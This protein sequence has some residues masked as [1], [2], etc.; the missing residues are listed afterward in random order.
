[1]SGWLDDVLGAYLD[2]VSER[3]FDGAFLALLASAG[4]SNIH[5]IH[6]AYEFGKDFIARRDGV[7]YGLQTKAGDI[8]LAPWR[9]IR[10]QIEEILWNDIAHPDFDVGLE[11]RAVLVTT[12]RLIGGAAAD[13]QQYASTL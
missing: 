11:R 5:L 8:G 13:A 2:A 12:G 7:Q 9:S 4:F 10:S 6:G 1:M 3:E